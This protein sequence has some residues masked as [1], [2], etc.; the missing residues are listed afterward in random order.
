MT[1][2][3]E[4]LF[5]LADFDKEDEGEVEVSTEIQVSQ[6]QIRELDTTL[7]KIDSALP[8][9]RELATSDTELDH[10]A[11]LAEDSFK[12]LMELGMNVEPMKSSEIFTT[13]SSMLGHAIS[14]KN[15][16]IDKKL[17]IVQLQIQKARLDLQARKM[18][19]EETPLD[20]E[21]RQLDR[22]EILAAILK[23]NNS[24]K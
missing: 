16:K 20:G 17:K 10:L 19:S 18:E 7:D 23:Q 8:S 15:S 6:Q 9:V 21:S 22:N 24:D 4:D 1:K 13:A 5:D 14:A 12:E 11:Q 2:K 3:L